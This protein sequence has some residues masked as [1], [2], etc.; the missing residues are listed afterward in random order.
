[1]CLPSTTHRINARVAGLHF[2]NTHTHTANI[3]SSVDSIISFP[4]CRWI[5][6]SCR[7]SFQRW[8]LDIRA[9]PAPV[10]VRMDS[11][12]GSEPSA[13]WTTA[14]QRLAWT[15]RG[16]RRDSF[17]KG[18]KR[19]W[20]RGLLPWKGKDAAPEWPQ[21]EKKKRWGRGL[22]QQTLGKSLHAR[23]LLYRHKKCMCTLKSSSQHEQPV[24]IQAS[25][26]YETTHA[27]NDEQSNPLNYHCGIK[28][29]CAS[30][31]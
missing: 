6:L 16:R 11:Q 3:V 9:S 12:E 30:F 23:C 31:R 22:R 2:P 19:L 27:T 24:V 29:Q 4:A 1:M 13:S 20:H 14:W 28:D 26:S 15:D 18:Y 21:W 5:W 8:P 7:S 10:H 17:S 25:P